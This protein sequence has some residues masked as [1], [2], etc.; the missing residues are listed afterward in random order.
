[1][2]T[3]LLFLHSGL[4]YDTVS[5]SNYIA[6]NTRITVNDELE[7]TWKEAVLPNKFTIPAFAGWRGIPRKISVMTAG[8]LVET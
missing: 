8:V 7:S 4:F 3:S 2:F 1:M 6:P 5:I